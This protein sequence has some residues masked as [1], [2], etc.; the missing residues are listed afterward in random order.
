MVLFNKRI[1][2]I[3]NTG[4]FAEITMFFVV[5][6]VELFH[7]LFSSKSNYRSYY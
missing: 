3:L 1:N 4:H 5:K 2:F 6:T 7:N